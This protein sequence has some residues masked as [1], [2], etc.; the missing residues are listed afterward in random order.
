LTGKGKVKTASHVEALLL[1][2]KHRGGGF[3]TLADMALS[4]LVTAS[5][6]GCHPQFP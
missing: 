3:T 4:L 1:L 2:F 5:F 6:F